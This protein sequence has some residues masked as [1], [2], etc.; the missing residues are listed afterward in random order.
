MCISHKLP[1]NTEA[2]VPQA[3]LRKPLISFKQVNLFEQK[4]A[5]GRVES[6][7]GRYPAQEQWEQV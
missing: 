4:A 7:V 1:G 3:T 5:Q 2:A 6:A